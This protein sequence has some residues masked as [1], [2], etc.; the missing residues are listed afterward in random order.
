MPVLPKQLFLYLSLSQREV[1]TLIFTTTSYCCSFLP[2]VCITA[3]AALYIALL[4]DLSAL[5]II[6]HYVFLLTEQAILQNSQDA[7]H[8]SC[9]C[10]MRIREPCPLYTRF[11]IIGMIKCW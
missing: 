9:Q 1:P 5:T 2:L 8:A 4:K 7:C 10:M 3:E 11:C 6:A